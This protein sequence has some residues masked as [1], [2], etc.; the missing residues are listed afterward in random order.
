[1]YRV[2]L[3]VMRTFGHND[4]YGTTMPV[5]SPIQPRVGQFSEEAL[6]RYDYV[7]DALSRVSPTKSPLAQQL[8]SNPE[9]GA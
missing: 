8:Q 6:K 4:G 1:M 3:K 5:R 7:M 9:G 2:G